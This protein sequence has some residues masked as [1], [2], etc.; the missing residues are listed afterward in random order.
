METNDSDRDSLVRLLDMDP[1][2]VIDLKYTTANNFTGRRVYD[3]EDCYINKSTA[4]LLVRAK[5]IFKRDGYQVEIWDAYRPI[6]AQRKLYEIVPVNEYVATP[7]DLNHAIKF[8][9]SHMNG[10]SVDLTLL[11][12]D[13]KELQMPTHFDDFSEMA[14]LAC[15]RI[16]HVSRKHAEYLKRIMESVGFEAYENEWWHFN[17]ILTSPTPYSDVRFD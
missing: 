2:F 14:R 16:P 9:H 17:D 4:K 10:L 11:D 12:S 8:T 3:F 6:R 5:N 7:P 1:E 15:G 13:G